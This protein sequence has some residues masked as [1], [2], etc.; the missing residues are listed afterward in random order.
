M[1]VVPYNCYGTFNVQRG[2]YAFNSR[3]YPHAGSV[4]GA[5][6]VDRELGDGQDIDGPLQL[7]L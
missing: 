7:V 2:V 5:T 4:E 3:V 1:C 6:D